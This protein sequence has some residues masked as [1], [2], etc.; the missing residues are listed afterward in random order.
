MRLRALGVIR[1]AVLELG[2]GLTVVTGETGAGKTMVVT[3]LGLLFGGRAD[4]A[5]VRGGQA[6]A[7]VEGRLRVDPTSPVAD[8]ARDA[9]GELEDDELILSRTVTAEGRSRADLGGRSVP[10]GVLGELAEHLIAVHGQSDQL[11]L[12]STVQQRQALDR[13]AGPAHADLLAEYRQ[14]WR[15]LRTLTDEL[16]AIRSHA[17]A[18]LQEAELLRLGLAE[19][20]RVD[21]KPLEDVELR[22]EA[23]RLGHAEEL[24]AAAALAHVALSGDA[25]SAAGDADAAS[26]LNA[27]RRGLDSV[28]H[29][30]P[31]LA[32][33][34]DRLGEV[35]VHITDIAAECAGYAESV[36]SDPARLAA[37]EDRR[38]VIGALVRAHGD[39]VAAVL[40]WARTAGLRL[41][42]LDGDDDRLAE[43]SEQCALL[44]SRLGVMAAR[45]S[46]ARTVAAEDLAKAVTAE[47]A[48]LAMPDARLDVAVEQRPA[49]PA[50][51]GALE[52]DTGTGPRWLVA[53]ADGVDDVEL[54]LAPH[55]GAPAR[56]VA[57]GASGGELSR[58]ML[59][60]EVVLG[61]A[62]PVPT[63]VFDEVDSGVGGTAALG[64]G[65]RLAR[66]AR[67]SQ[68]V[69]V[70]H[71]PQVAA[72]ADRHLL[73]R[74]E[75]DG[76]VTESGVRVL[77]QAERVRELA[78]M[79]GGMA[80]SETAR[81][82][83]EELL[84]AA[85]SDAAAPA[86]APARAAARS[87][88]AAVGRNRSARGTID[89]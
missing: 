41:L 39:D 44:Q 22:A 80:D 9:G 64:I 49:E 76:H 74:K 26:L 15:R 70:T 60:I 36:E 33:L 89:R 62:D 3:G 2:P 4:S 27:A 45:I 52:V 59:G 13:F 20:D 28:R 23:Q 72:Y 53:T 54:L 50:Q 58:V 31:Q 77:D 1:D 79:L 12:R 17:R 6:S 19:V 14:T 69:V 43:M 48:D 82:H 65:R 46:Q 87:V 88:G 38:A 29:H 83:A 11:R 34:A 18:R 67:T 8:R 85:R 66:L 57:K 40:D 51:S 86:R 7:S 21:P 30:D 56:P 71:L 42:E 25:G 16:D 32:A 61:A 24:Q 73:V 63:F 35:A 5:A 37:V 75:T 68:V 78:R 47:L 55:P 84:A 10:V 81:A